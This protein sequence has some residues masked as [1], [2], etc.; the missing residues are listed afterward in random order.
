M[1]SFTL[2][3][4]SQRESQVDEVCFLCGCQK[5]N[6]API[7]G[8][9]NPSLFTHS[10][11]A[12]HDDNCRQWKV[13]S[14]IDAAVERCPINH[15]MNLER[16]GRS[17]LPRMRFMSRIQQFHSHNGQCHVRGGIIFKQCPLVLSCEQDTDEEVCRELIADPD[18]STSGNVSPCSNSCGPGVTE[19]VF[20]C[21]HNGDFI[22]RI[23]RRPCNLG[24][25]PRKKNSEKILSCGIGIMT[26]SWYCQNMDIFLHQCQRTCCLRPCSVTV[27]SGKS[28]TPKGYT[29]EI[30]EQSSQISTG[31]QGEHTCH[32]CD[33]VYSVAGKLGLSDNSAQ[34]A[35]LGAQMSW[36]TR[37]PY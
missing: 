25:C 36:T 14:L 18:C 34:T 19:E 8:E 35:R 2:K 30:I 26:E 27:R 28:Y 29:E 16:H 11:D 3:Y 23:C 4:K 21:D 12:R 9:T 33:L 13:P 37:P 31:I 17:E 20:W 24:S 1:E 7:F 15:I 6:N 10:F 22:N 5:V 32:N